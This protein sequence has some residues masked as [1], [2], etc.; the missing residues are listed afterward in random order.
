MGSVVNF[1]AVVLYQSFMSTWRFRPALIF[2]IVVGSLA[3]IVDLIIVM[4]WNIKWGI[5]DELFFL[6]GNAV[7]ESL[8]TILI[9][10]P[11]SSIFAKV[12]IYQLGS[13]TCNPMC[14][15]LLFFPTSHQ[16][17]RLLLQEW[18]RQCTSI[19]VCCVLQVIVKLQA[20][21]VH[22]ISFYLNS[23]AYTVGITNFC[24]MLSGLLGSGIIEWSGM[25]TVGDN[26][27]F[28]QLPYII[29]LW[30]VLIPMLIG[31]P[32]TFLIPN[33][34]QTENLID[35]EKERWYESEHE[36]VGTSDEDGED[37]EDSR[38]EPHLL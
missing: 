36:G 7:F 38:I 25:V 35:W 27:N 21:H 8:V 34:L 24:N 18:S 20:S 17:D 22:S 10:I 4:R 14:F 19:V 1:V 11:M 6:L 29:V 13:L 2:T 15:C 3:P 28:D 16:N 33:V 23:F 31:I 5:S 26:C 9:G 32:A 37:V 30:K 12:S